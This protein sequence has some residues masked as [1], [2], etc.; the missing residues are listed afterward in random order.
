MK[1]IVHIKRQKNEELKETLNSILNNLRG[2]AFHASSDSMF[3]INIETTIGNQTFETTK[4]F[5]RSQ[6]VNSRNLQLTAIQ[7]AE[8]AEAV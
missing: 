1:I 4:S 6:V 5:S 3:S 7:L 2:L 8:K